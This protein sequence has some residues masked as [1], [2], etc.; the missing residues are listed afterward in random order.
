MPRGRWP[1]RALQLWQRKTLRSRNS[2]KSQP[3]AGITSLGFTSN[4]YRQRLHTAMTCHLP[5]I[6]RA[7]FSGC[8]VDGRSA[9]CRRRRPCCSPTAHKAFTSALFRGELYFRLRLMRV[10]AKEKR[11]M[12]SIIYLVGLVVVVMLVLSMLGLR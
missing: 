5:P 3:K 9:D 12:H 7:T 11:A 2:G 6:N 4:R 8:C 10:P 1:A